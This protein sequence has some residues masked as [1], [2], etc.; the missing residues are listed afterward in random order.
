MISKII[1]WFIYFA[2]F[3]WNVSVLIRDRMAIVV[4]DSVCWDPRLR[5]HLEIFPHVPR[6][7]YTSR[8]SESNLTAEIK[9]LPPTF[10]LYT[11]T[12]NTFAASVRTLIVLELPLCL[13]VGF[14]VKSSPEVRL[15]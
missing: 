2:Y 14:P 1:P 4:F 3:T 9:Q 15:P 13:F 10:V 12:P 5:H 11:P 8:E 6:E 7:T